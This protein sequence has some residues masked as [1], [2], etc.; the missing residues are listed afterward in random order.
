[1]T[2]TIIKLGRQKVCFHPS[3]AVVMRRLQ[4]QGR[5]AGIHR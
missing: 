1:V 3:L 2:R 5:L 4:Q